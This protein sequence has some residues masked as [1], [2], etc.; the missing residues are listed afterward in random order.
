[1]VEFSVI[2]PAI[3]EAGRI[4]ACV[5]RVRRLAPDSQVIV[6][7]GGSQDETAAQARQAGA[8]VVVA[9][10]GRGT[11]CNAGAALAE[12]A[13]LLFLHADTLLPEA[14]FPLLRHTFAD[15]QVQI[16][17]F[18]LAFAEPHWLLRTYAWFSRF[19]TVF[20]RFGDQCIVVRR[21]FF[22]HLGGFPPWPLFEDVGLL[23]QARRQTRVYSF[24]ATVTTSARRYLQVGVVRQQMRNLGLILQYLAGAPPEDLARQ[25]EKPHNNSIK[26]II[27]DWF[28]QPKRK[29]NPHRFGVGPPKEKR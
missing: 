6:A 19:D 25:Y 9:C 11:Q 16:G 1:M 5:A 7:D 26:D 4:G 28:L 15:S 20:T 14:A 23:Q 21:A 8:Q 12:G 29:Q 22:A 24:P 17:S 18:R 13:L 27:A 2:I 10:P 3:N